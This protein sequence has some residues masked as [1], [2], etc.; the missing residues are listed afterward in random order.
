MTSPALNAQNA[1]LRALTVTAWEDLSRGLA[2]SELWGRL[3]WLEV[4]RRYQRTVLGP[5]WTSISLALY[6]I[7]VGIVG[8]GLWHQ[9]IREYLPFFVSGMVAWFLVSIIVAEAC[10]LLVSSHA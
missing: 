9:E 5:F 7:S 10:S 8:A 3:G 4:K 2:K 6:V 1:R